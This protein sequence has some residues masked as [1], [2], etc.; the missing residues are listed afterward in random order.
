[1]KG[2]EYPDFSIPGPASYNTRKDPGQGKLKFSLRPRTTLNRYLDLVALNESKKVP[3]HGTY[4]EINGTTLKGFQFLSKFKSSK[5]SVFH[6]PNSARFKEE[7]FIKLVSTAKK[8]PGP[9]TY[10]PITNISQNGSYF[11]AKFKSSLCRTFCPSDQRPTS[12]PNFGI[13]NS[14]LLAQEPIDILL[15]LDIIGPKK[16]M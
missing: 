5:A 3:G 11:I 7:S 12:Q 6:P 15:N 13:F 8:N 2:H 10:D 16:S 9:G 4:H 14:K 1:M